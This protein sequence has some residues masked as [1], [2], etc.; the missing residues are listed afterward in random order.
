MKILTVGGGPGGLYASLLLKKLNPA[1]DITLV[2]R[3]PAG[4]TYGWGVVFSSLT[5]TAFREA[6]YPTYKDITDQFV[7]WDPI[8][9]RFRGEVLRCGGNTFAG[10]SRRKLLDILAE[11]AAALG[12]TMQFET[13]LTD[14]SV[15]PDYDLVI[16]V[17]GINSTIRKTYADVFK[18][19]LRVGKARYIWFGTHKVFD[20]F[21]FII[22]ENEHG[23]FQA[24]IYPFDGNTGTF[25]VECDEGTWLN[26]GLDALDEAASIAYCEALF[27][28]DLGGQ[29]LMSN[30]SAWINFVE[31]KNKTWGHGNI[32][33]LGDA[34]H[35][36]HFSIGSG[37]KL[38]MED[39]I[40]LT[41]AF[42]LHGENVKAAIKA[43]ELDRRPRV[44][45]LQQSAEES[46]T[47]FETLKRYKH[48]E[49]TQ[50]AFH[51]LTRS[52]RLNYDNLR[53]RDPHFLDK[54]DRWFSRK[55]S[56]TDGRSGA[57]PLTPSPSGRG[58][59]D[60]AHLAIDTYPAVYR[61]PPQG[62][63]SNTEN[64]SLV[65]AL[66]PMHTPLKVRDMVL[67]NRVVLSAV[68]DY[69]AQDG[70]PDESYTNRVVEQAQS[71][72]A[73][74]LTEPVAVSAAGRI[75]PGCN[76]LYNDQHQAAWEI[77]VESVHSASIKI[78]LQLSHAGRRG[79]TRPR[80]YGLDK[81][82][83]EGNWSLLAPSPLP[84]TPQSQTP[85]AMEH[86][87]MEQVC[88]AFVSAAQRANAA[89]FDLLML[90]MAHGYLLGGF[91]S[92]LTNQRSDDYGGTLDNRL[93]FPLD[94]LDA[95]RAVWSASKP[96]AVAL[97]A[98]DWQSGGIEIE[99]ATAAVTILKAHGCDMVYLLAGQTTP[100]DH[101]TYGPNFL[102]KYAE[103][104]KNDTGMMHLTGGGI[105]TSNQINTLLAGGSADLCILSPGN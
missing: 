49:P 78:G 69:A 83:R 56:L 86:A 95:V 40:A 64:A 104:V 9:V 21:T 27:S 61:N 63:G 51:L 14:F 100:D 3:N 93:R 18:P 44:D 47:Y 101:P 87:D 12:V 66:P 81:P 50:F 76:G 43:Y 77:L 26:T 6:D 35:T 99:D 52:G 103:L 74:L 105:T 68:P 59:E 80:Q 19:S 92:P 54:V 102:S 1:N 46:Q 33:L 20:S 16:A 79:S 91:L 2:E 97:N 42:E 15:F 96:L 38:A 17:D 62:E 4:A 60:T 48:L 57:H 24:H 45:N 88:A 8:D 89:G 71:G 22:K 36:A 5:L 23:L 41:N 10:M 94:V 7:I 55:P 65:V 34:A 39:A 67:S 85:K 75:T 28:D 72:A 37:T 98:D 58:E 82:L 73:L 25:I 30:K 11:R 53:L 90:N 31:V 32:V 84:Y 70:V 29:H 13:E